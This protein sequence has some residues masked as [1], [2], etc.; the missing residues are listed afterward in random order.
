V[1]NPKNLGELAL[2]AQGATVPE[3]RTAGF[4]SPGFSKPLAGSARTEPKER[5]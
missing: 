2:R 1:F 3:N 4:L 5:Q